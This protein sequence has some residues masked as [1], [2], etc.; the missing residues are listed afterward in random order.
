MHNTD[1]NTSKSAEEMAVF[2]R[3]ETNMLCWSWGKSKFYILDDQECRLKCT[4]RLCCRQLFIY[5]IYIQHCLW[6]NINKISISYIIMT[7]VAC[8]LINILLITNIIS[9]LKIFRDSIDIFEKTIEEIKSD[10]WP[11]S[12]TV[13]IRIGLKV[14]IPQFSFV[15]Q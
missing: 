5:F 7:L 15:N 1:I 12:E 6:P 8:N 10:M 3:K 9:L 2:N 4:C 13:A 11:T 14:Q